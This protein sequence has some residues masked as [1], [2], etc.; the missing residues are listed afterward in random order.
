MQSEQW[1]ARVTDGSRVLAWPEIY[2][3][4]GIRLVDAHMR[5]QT[6]YEPLSDPVGLSDLSSR[7]TD[8][9]C[10]TDML[11]RRRGRGSKSKVRDEW[12]FDTAA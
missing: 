8:S 5:N 7:A 2:L 6:A 11:K 10:S 1:S 9:S 4:M 12:Y 3:E